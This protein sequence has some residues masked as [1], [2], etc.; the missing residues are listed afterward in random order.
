MRR[1]RRE[2][3]TWTRDTQHTPG[4]KAT[5]TSEH[6]L[7]PK[8]KRLSS[9]L[10]EWTG[11]TQTLREPNTGWRRQPSCWAPHGSSCSFSPLSSVGAELWVCCLLMLEA[12][13]A[14]QRWKLNVPPS[15]SEEAQVAQ[16]SRPCC[17]VYLGADVFSAQQADCKPEQ[18][19]HGPLHQE[20]ALSGVDTQVIEMVAHRLPHARHA[21]S[22]RHTNTLVSEEG[23]P[24]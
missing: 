12:A 21:V 7:I 13:G 14:N 1:R 17:S 18:S 2:R 8:H 23:E 3:R 19:H 6:K 20:A 16:V 5:N 9:F 11:R 24:W 4:Q 10:D 15:G 22:A